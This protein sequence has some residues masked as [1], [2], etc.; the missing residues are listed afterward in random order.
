MISLTNLEDRFLQLYKQRTDRIVTRRQE[1]V[2]DQCIE[3]SISKFFVERK[4]H[5]N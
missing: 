1:D 5:A 3:Y 4:Y 2:K